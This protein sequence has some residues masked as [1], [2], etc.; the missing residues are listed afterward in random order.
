MRDILMTYVM[1]DFDLGKL[2]IWIVF[3][4]KVFLGYVQ[5]M[6][7]FLGPLMVV[8]EDEVDSFWSFIGLMKRVVSVFGKCVISNILALKLWNGPNGNQETTVKFEESNW[9]H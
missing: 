2:T 9:D 8:M 3:V 7:D 6:S 5:G 1:Y 4:I